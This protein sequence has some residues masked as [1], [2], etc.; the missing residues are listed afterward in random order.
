MGVELSDRLFG[1]KKNIFLFIYIYVCFVGNMAVSVLVSVWLIIHTY[2][3]FYFFLF[4]TQIIF[5]FCIFLWFNKSLIWCRRFFVS[6][7]NNCIIEKHT[8][9]CIITRGGHRLI[10]LI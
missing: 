2:H 6:V 8:V 10:F 5:T 3:F 7:Y 1:E 9:V 4:I